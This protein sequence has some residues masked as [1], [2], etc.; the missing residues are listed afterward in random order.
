MLATLLLFG[1]VFFEQTITSSSNAFSA[2]AQTA[3][4]KSKRKPNTARRTYRGG[5]RVTRKGWY[6]TKWAGRKSW[7]SGRKVVSRTKK[8]FK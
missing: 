3:T 4:V 6:K 2:S 8:V 7:R 5:K 1:I